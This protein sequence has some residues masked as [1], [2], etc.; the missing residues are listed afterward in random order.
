MWRKSSISYAIFLLRA[1]LLVSETYD[2]S[3]FLSYQNIGNASLMLNNYIKN[4]IFLTFILKQYF[5]F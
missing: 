2:T 5:I 1:F 4:A 3:K